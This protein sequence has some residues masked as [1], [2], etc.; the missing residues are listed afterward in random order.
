VSQG[1]VV[2]DPFSPGAF[3]VVFGSTS[4][5]WVDPDDP[6]RLEFEYVQR[7]A[8]ALEVTV[9]TR[10]PEERIRVV[11]LGGGGLTL[12]RWVAFRRPRTAQ[13]VCEP[14]AELTKEVRRKIPLPPRSG[15]KV[16]DVDART[17]VSAM[18]DAYADATILDAFVGAQVPA[19]L[20]SGEFFLEVGRC[21]RPGG[22]FLANIADE[23][24]FGWA[25]RFVS[26]V[27]SVF[28][29]TAVSAESAVW[30]GRRYGNLVLLASGTPLPLVELAREAAGAPFPYRVLSGR[31]LNRWLGGAVPF[32][33]ADT[34]QS[35][36]P[37]G[38]RGWFS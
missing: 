38:G 8:S 29:H 13:I 14:D 23:A 12:P 30:K 4:H 9:L 10:P 20:A 2:P 37:P 36:G 34:I 33:D 22:V 6:E 16:R 24:P 25:K 26:G 7:I 11:H 35:P 21:S 15:I 1:R 27:I 31:E 32:T 17:G 28:R 18:P 5:S 3:R 19:E